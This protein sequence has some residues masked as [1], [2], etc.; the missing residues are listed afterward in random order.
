MQR[1]EE[2]KKQTKLWYLRCCPP[3][4]SGISDRTERMRPTQI[5]KQFIFHLF[6]N[7]QLHLTRLQRNHNAHTRH[8]RPTRGELAVRGLLWTA[9]GGYISWWKTLW[10][11]FPGLIQCKYKVSASIWAFARKWKGEFSRRCLVR[12]RN[13]VIHSWEG[14]CFYWPPHWLRVGVESRLPTQGCD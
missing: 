13:S 14:F 4:G 11:P 3:Q 5:V 2:E 6:S 8:Q 10:C 9:R 7:F 12:E 1:A